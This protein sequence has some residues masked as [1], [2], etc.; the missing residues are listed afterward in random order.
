MKKLSLE[1]FRKNLFYYFKLILKVN[2]FV[3]HWLEPATLDQKGVSSNP[4][5][6]TALNESCVSSTYPMNCFARTTMLGS[7]HQLYSI[8]VVA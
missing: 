7:V 8:T 3:L 6:A 4:I 1:I 2:A 5:E